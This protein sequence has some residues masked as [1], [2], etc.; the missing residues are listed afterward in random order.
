MNA[1]DGP[2]ILFDEERFDPRR[3]MP[4][5]H[6][7]MSHPLLQLD[8]L[9]ALGRRLAQT[10]SVRWHNDD[11]RPDS[12]FQ[13]APEILKPKWDAITSLER[14][15]DAKAWVSLLN[16]QQDSIYRG[17][18]DEILN[19]VQPR[20]RHRDPGMS[21]R[22]GWIFITSPHAITPFHI[23]H[24]HNFILQ[25]AGTKTL[26]VWEPLD[27]EVLSEAALE[28]FHARYSRELVTWRPEFDA[29]VHKFELVPGM[30]GFMPT[31]SAH[32][33]KNGP[34]V[35]ITISATYYT[36][37]T[38]RT[39]LLYRANHWLRRIGLRPAPVGTGGVSEAMK[40]AAFGATRR[41][42]HAI[43]RV[44][45]QQTEDLNVSYAPV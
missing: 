22:A 20:V 45:G 34:E 6:R 19:D 38:R 14:I 31:T 35:S 25:I 1:Y 15:N 23:D 21:F 30:G 26:H 28:L 36:D 17:L 44:R 16:V 10:N 43:K 40:L 11:A 32:W 13:T 3:V 42:L 39:K 24:E 9:V 4:V 18:V 27:R 41:S 29:R 5:T 7:L 8:N 12:S 37:L 2:G 33:V